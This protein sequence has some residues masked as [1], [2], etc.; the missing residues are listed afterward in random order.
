VSEDQKFIID[1]ILSILNLL[2][3]ATGLRYV[4]Y[5]LNRTSKTTQGEFLLNLDEKMNDFAD[6][7]EATFDNDWV[8]SDDKD[9]NIAGISWA[10]IN[11]YM[12]L[13]ERIKILIDDDIVNLELFTRLYGYKLRYLVLNDAIYQRKLL[14]QGYGWTDFIKL[15]HDL[16]DLKKTDESDKKE[17]WETFQKR[18]DEVYRKYPQQLS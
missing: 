12:G 5:E 3:A 13:F 8:P 15:A 9:T 1:V 7:T 4:W 6:V 14:G 10:R 2:V 17:Q 18:I 16:A 11:N